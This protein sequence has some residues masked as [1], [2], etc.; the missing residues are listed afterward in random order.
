MEK[1][2]RNI[3]EII[4]EKKILVFALV[5]VLG[6][7]L[8][9]YFIL[10]PEKTLLV[11]NE[12]ASKGIIVEYGNTIDTDVEKYVNK[13]LLENKDKKEIKVET[14]AKNEEGKEYPAVGKYKI[15]ITYKKEKVECNVEV[16][17]TVAPTFNNF[18]SLEFIQGTDFDYNK[19]VKAEDLSKVEITYDTSTINK[20]V[21]G[22]YSLKMLASDLYNTTEKV[23]AVKVVAKPTEQ[24]D[25]K[26]VEDIENGMVKVIVS[27]K[28]KVEASKPVVETK[29][30]TPNQ[31]SNTGF[32]I[33]L[34]T[35]Y[36]NQYAYG[37][38]MGCEAASLLQALQAKGY[39]NGVGLRPMLDNMPYTTDGNPYNGFVSSP[40]IIDDAMVYQSIFPSALTPYGNQYGTCIN[41][42]GSSPAQLVEQLKAGNPSVVYVTYNFAYPK[43]DTY[44]FGNCTSNMHVMTLIGYNSN[45]GKYKVMDPAGQGA[46]W[47][48]KKSFENA[49]NALRFAITIK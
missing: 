2:M 5:F 15:T 22:D 30:Q 32:V 13:E 21:P 49:Y 25:V 29:P 26:V 12:K 17:D 36:I 14:N 1:N 8:V 7:V 23:L 41:T 46:Y 38:P 39:A 43:W 44:S 35:P 40:Y 20:A 34:S 27:D 33:E 48:S 4:I 19:Y 47:V 28:P 10:Q 42:S 18:Q 11:V 3:K 31:S 16:K 45:T 37:A 9:I 6:I 24:Q